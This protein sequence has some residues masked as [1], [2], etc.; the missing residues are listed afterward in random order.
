MEQAGEHGAE[1]V[2]RAVRAQ[3]ADA[4][5]LPAGDGVGDAVGVFEAHRPQRL[6]GRVRGLGAAEIQAGGVGRIGHRAE[7]VV[8]VMAHAVE[9]AQQGV[10]EG[11]AVGVAH[12][13]REVFDPGRG[14][15]QHVGLTIGHHLEPVFD[16]AQ[17]AIRG[18]QFGGGAG[19]Q[20]ASA[21]Q[22]PQGHKGACLAQG[23]VSAAPDELQGLDQELDLADAALAELHV[24]AGDDGHLRRGAGE[25]GFLV[26]VDAALHGVDVGHGGE[27]Q[28][29]APDEG[30]DRLE[31]GG[32]H[33][34]VAGDGTGL[35]HGR[36]F[37]VLAHA[38]VVGDGGVQVDAGRRGGWVRAQAQIG[39]KHV[40][41][42]VAGLHQG[43]EAARQSAKPA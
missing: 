15:G 36:A 31:E 13:D 12:E 9:L 14:F 20:V 25:R 3:G 7:H 11:Q 35:E 39:P 38:F 40:A 37:P 24:V 5:G 8:V 22:E 30:A 26:L 41:V 33:R 1:Q 19:R 21:N 23:G 27:I 10:G 17:E 34:E 4:A 42:D 32:A 29:P 2:A 18:G 16:R 28:V 6:G 43:D